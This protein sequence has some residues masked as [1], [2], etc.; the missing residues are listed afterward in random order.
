MKADSQTTVR[1]ITMEYPQAARVFESFGNRLLL[2]RQRRLEAL[3]CPVAAEEVFDGG[4]TSASLEEIA[5]Q[6]TSSC[7]RWT[8]N[9]E[10]AISGRT[11]L[12]S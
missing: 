12:H 9:D 7:P 11:S 4:W 3:R 2:R 5:N 6:F 10:D 8:D 1:E